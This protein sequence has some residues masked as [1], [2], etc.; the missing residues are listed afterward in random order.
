MISK[1]FEGKTDLQEEW[2][3][4]EYSVSKISP[5][6]IEVSCVISNKTFTAKKAFHG[7]YYFSI[8]DHEELI[9]LDQVSR[10]TPLR[11]PLKSPHS[12]AQSTKLN[13]AANPVH[14]SCDT[15]TENSNL[16]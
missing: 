8:T 16:S 12:R 2:Y 6:F 7:F 9:H 10:K 5:K 11:L 15:W 4:T 1:A 13:P 14:Q 3:G